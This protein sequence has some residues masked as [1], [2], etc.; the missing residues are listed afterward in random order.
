MMSLGVHLR[1]IGRPG[2][3]AYFERFRQHVQRHG[4]VWIAPRKAIADHW[5]T[6][7]PPREV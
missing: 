6:Q 2:R 5:A 3:I 4:R 7:D 1:I